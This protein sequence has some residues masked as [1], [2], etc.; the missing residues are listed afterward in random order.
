MSCMVDKL[1][2]ELYKMCYYKLQ[3]IGLYYVTDDPFLHLKNVYGYIYHTHTG[4][5]VKL[6]MHLLIV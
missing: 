2:I 6:A 5:H 3:S 1:S 4:C